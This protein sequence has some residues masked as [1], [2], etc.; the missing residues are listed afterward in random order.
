MIF[1][2]FVNEASI[3][4]TPWSVMTAKFSSSLAISAIAAQTLAKTSLSFDFNK[5]TMSS[6]PP[7]KFLTVSPESYSF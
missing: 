5:E 1:T 7:T 3:G 4:T 2:V 6:K